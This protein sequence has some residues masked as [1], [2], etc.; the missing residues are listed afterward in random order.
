MVR[1]SRIAT[2]VTVIPI[3]LLTIAIAVLGLPNP[4]LIE[5]G[6]SSP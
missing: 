5:T 2:L 1:T 6:G 4:D 3:I